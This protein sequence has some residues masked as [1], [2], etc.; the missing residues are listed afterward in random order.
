MGWK[1]DA[2]AAV[3]WAA[4]A[5]AV[6]VGGVVRA[7]GVVDLAGAAGRPDARTFVAVPPPLLA[8]AEQRPALSAVF[9]VSAAGPVGGL[10]RR[11][12]D[13]GGVVAASPLVSMASARMQRR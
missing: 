8:E 7:D 2:A 11:R 6:V 9:Q 1:D 13:A 5:G 3:G 12:S 10:R 4:V